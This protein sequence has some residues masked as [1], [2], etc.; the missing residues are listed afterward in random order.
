MCGFMGLAAKNRIP[1]SGL[2]FKLQVDSDDLDT[3]TYFYAGLDG[4]EYIIKASK[5]VL[6]EI[7]LMRKTLRQLAISKWVNLF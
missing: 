6:L 1:L 2:T 3:S 7:Q 4:I 5:S